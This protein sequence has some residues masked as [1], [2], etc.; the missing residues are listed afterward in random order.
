VSKDRNKGSPLHTAGKKRTRKPDRNVIIDD[1]DLCVVKRTF[2]LKKK[3]LPTCIT[4]L[5]II[6]GNKFFL[7]TTVFKKNTA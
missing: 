4:I 2:T 3:I 7:G 1:F 6:I 5:S